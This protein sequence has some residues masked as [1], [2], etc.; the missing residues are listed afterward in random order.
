[1]HREGYIAKCT[2]NIFIFLLLRSEYF[3]FFATKCTSQ[4]DHIPSAIWFTLYPKPGVLCVGKIFEEETNRLNP[5]AVDLRIFQ[6]KGQIQIQGWTQ[7]D[8]LR[9]EKNTK[10]WCK[11]TVEKWKRRDQVRRG[12]SRSGENIVLMF[13]PKRVVRIL[14]CRE[15]AT[16]GFLNPTRAWG[17]G[18][19]SGS[20]WGKGQQGQSP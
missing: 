14:S 11:F 15:E 1:M 3:I 5:E 16:K 4:I 19:K 9:K 13:V 20:M 12:S 6:G 17:L 8:C 18:P 10:T 7:F 2:Q